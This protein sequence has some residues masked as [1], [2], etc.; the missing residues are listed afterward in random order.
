MSLG[1]M[2][3]GGNPA[4]GRQEDDFYPTPPEP[5][6]ALLNV[7][8]FDGRIH[9][10]ACGDG[11]MA[12]IIAAYGYD[13]IASDLVPR[14][15]GSQHDFLK[16]T[17]KVSHNIIT[18]PPFDLAEKFIRHALEVQRPRKLALLLKSTYF[19]AKNRIPLFEQHPP[20]IIYPLTWRVDFLGKGRPTM[21]CSWFVWHR[22]NTD[23]PTYQ[24]LAKPTPDETLRICAITDK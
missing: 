23:L 3:A 9:E 8:Q 11:T 20:K 1:A 15:Y 4:E 24:L 6:I 7:E 21:E 17:K 13:V 5:T 14:G 16:I 18:N 10:C 12:K 22:G 2:M 19:H